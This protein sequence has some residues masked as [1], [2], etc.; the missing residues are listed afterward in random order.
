MRDSTPADVSLTTK[1]DFLSRPESYP[2]AT[3]AVQAVET[4]FSW[5]FLAGTRAYKLKKPVREEFLDFTTLEA[6]RF[7]CFEEL[8]L[9]RRLAPDV[10][11]DVVPLTLSDGTALALGG[12]GP[13]V[14]WLVEM[15]CLPAG[16]MLDQ[17]I[18]AGTLEESALRRTVLRLVEFYRSLPS[19]PLTAGDYRSRFLHDLQAT[20]DVFS[21]AP[22]RLD[23]A[24]QASTEVLDSFIQRRP[25]RFDRRIAEG[26]IVEG[27]G[28]LRPEHVFVGD[29]V[30][31]FID[32]LEFNRGFR[33][34]DPVDELSF[35][36]M[37]CERLGAPDVGEQV[38]ATYLSASGDYVP[39]DLIAFYKGYRACLRAKLAF[40]HTQDHAVQD[41]AKWLVRSREYLA[42]AETHTRTLEVDRA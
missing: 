17:R 18:A 35:L 8:R 5:V 27:H 25:D 38:M 31:V 28:D 29:E 16:Q 12:T 15:R 9:N 41:P 40:L 26:R 20:R 24:A 34:L 10:Y 2:Q 14:D 6:R 21:K 7:D 36:A 37:E 23:E 13:A 32:C 11:L 3:D 19:E 33:I 22:A 39:E 30:P 1:V 4:H 42:L